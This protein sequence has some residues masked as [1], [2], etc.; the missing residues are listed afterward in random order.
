MSEKNRIQ[1]TRVFSEID[2]A[3]RN[4]YTVISLQ[5]SSR[6]SKTY[7]VLIWLFMYALS[8]PNTMVSIVRGT[9]PA[10]RGSVLRDFKEIAMRLG[11][12]SDNAMNRSEMVFSLYNGSQFEFFSVDNEQ[13][14]RG[15]KRDILFVNEAN[16]I[17]FIEWQ[18][19]KLRTTKFAI[20]DYN[21]SFSDEHWIC[22]VNKDGKTYHFISTYK[23]NPFLEQTIV[24]EIESLQWKN[25]TLWQVYGLGL[26]AMV[27]GLVFPK[28]EYVDAVP[29]HIKKHF[30][31]VDFGYTNDPTAMVD[32][33]FDTEDNNEVMYVDELC[34]RTHMTNG[35]IIAELKQRGRIKVD[36]ESADPRMVDE[37]YSAGINIFPVKKYA[38][39]VEAGVLRMQQFVIRVTKRSANVRKE[40]GN[41]TYQQDKNGKWLNAP[42]D[43]F[44]HAIDA[45]RYVVL[46]EVMKPAQ[47]TKFS[48]T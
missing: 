39:S 31:G 8:H 7:N 2:V 29:A 26:Q 20:M 18:Q 43:A 13:K 36:S 21:P 23:D 34:Y 19:L 25:P 12:W 28:V 33:C 44:N 22:G 46:T 47:T 6:S 45:I 15:R 35:E 30:I 42:V 32:V 14:L 11:V 27:E 40:F 38:G 4:G 37:I 1:T 9:F 24:D 41:Y 17:A 48:L 16:E 5:G 3:V 10:L